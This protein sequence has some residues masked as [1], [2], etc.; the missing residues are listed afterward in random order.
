MKI[1]SGILLAMVAAKPDRKVPPRHPKN[2]LN[3]LQNKL[4]VSVLTHPG[5]PWKPKRSQRVLNKLQAFADR[6][7]KSFER[8]TCGYYD[9]TTRHGG[10]DPE[11]HLR[12]NGK[13][14]NP[15]N[16]KRRDAEWTPPSDATWIKADSSFMWLYEYCFTQNDEVLKNE[17]GSWNDDRWNFVGDSDDLICLDE[18][19][20]CASFDMSTCQWSDN[21]GNVVPR[22]KRGGRKLS[23]DPQIAW[24][25]VTTGLKK[26]AQRYLNN[27][28][29]MRKNNLPARRAKAMYN[30]WVAEFPNEW[31]A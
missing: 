16:R 25:Q 2:R 6:M 19:D 4:A 30:R 7:L 20:T 24:K 1:L 14:R 31:G 28:H 11:P 13:A 23:D 29:G 26:W 5:L 3:R 10:P 8:P 22:G 18:D 15:T 17:D 12:E 27:C 21:L 9:P